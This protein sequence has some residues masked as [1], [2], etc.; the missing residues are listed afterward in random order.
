MVGIPPRVGKVA[1]PL[2]PAPE[3][4]DHSPGLQPL[5]ILATAG[6]LV[7]LNNLV[8]YQTRRYQRR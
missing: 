2:D 3:R 7:N 5:G 1:M 4:V 8:N 6:M